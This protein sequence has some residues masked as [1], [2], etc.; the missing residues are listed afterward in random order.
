[1]QLF[2]HQ[3]TEKVL[4]SRKAHRNMYIYNQKVIKYNLMSFFI[5]YSIYTQNRVNIVQNTV[6][7]YGSKVLTYIAYTICRYIL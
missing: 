5:I 3:W 4:N 6:H 7:N 1:M 2:I